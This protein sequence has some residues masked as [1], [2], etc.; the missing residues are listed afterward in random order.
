[1][2]SAPNSWLLIGVNTIYEITEIS[3]RLYILPDSNVVLAEF[4]EGSWSIQYVYRIIP[5]GELIFNSYGTWK[6]QKIIK[7]SD[8]SLTRQRFNF[9]QSEI[10]S[11]VAY[12]NIKTLDHLTDYT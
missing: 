9:Q 5:G 7:E 1:M 11:T 4:Q 12:N 8:E 10:K 3:S 6:D 2:F